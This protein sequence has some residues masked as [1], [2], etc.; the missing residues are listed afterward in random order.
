[1]TTLRKG[2]EVSKSYRAITFLEKRAKEDAMK[3]LKRGRCLI[4]VNPP[5]KRCA[6]KDFLTPIMEWLIS[7]QSISSN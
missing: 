6:Y 7:H 3:G 2:K 4:T 1:L 5:T